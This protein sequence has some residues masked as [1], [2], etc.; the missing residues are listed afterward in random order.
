MTDN[1]TQTLAA[2][3]APAVASF[4][5]AR[6][7]PMVRDELDRALAARPADVREVHVTTLERG[8]VNVGR[9]HAQFPTLVQTVGAGVPVWLCG[10]AG[11]GK[12]VAGERVAEALGM[13]FSAVSVGPHTSQSHLMGYMDAT[14]TY[15]GTEVRVRYEH[16]GVLLIDE[17][18]RGNPGVLTAL[19]ALLAN[20]VCAFPDGMIARHAEFRVIAAAN[21]IGMGADRQY[22]GAVQLDAATLDR[23]AVLDWPY[24]D[25]FELE[26]AGAAGGEI[27][28]QWAKRVQSIRAAIA[29]LKV[30]HVVSPRATLGGIA[31]LRSGLDRATVA[32]MVVWRGLDANTRERVEEHAGEEPYASVAQA[33]APWASAPDPEPAEPTSLTPAG[34]CPKCAEDRHSYMSRIVPGQAFCWRKRGGCG[35]KWS[36]QS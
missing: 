23:F 3:L 11:S 20:A 17:I 18:D 24:D 31:L 35:H 12:T 32:N 8:T 10:P 28:T 34:R 21:T 7:A 29:E 36:V 15:R 1:L 16:G 13:P 25:A 33:A 30:R 9:Q 26:L 22:V 6:F 5:E 14:G 27:G 4:L 2:A 19:N